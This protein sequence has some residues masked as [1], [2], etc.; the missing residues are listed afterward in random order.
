MENDTEIIPQEMDTEITENQEEVVIEEVPEVPEESIEDLKKKLA[1]AEAQKEHWRSKAK[2][3][4]VAPTA[5][6]SS[7]DLV[8]VTNAKIHEDDIERV[9]RFARSEGLSIKEAL[10]DPELN[11]MLDLRREQRN[12]ADATNIGNVRAGARSVPDEVLL[13]NA[14]KGKLPETDLEIE[15]LIMAKSRANQG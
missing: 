5:S 7:A 1:T 2:E 8:A 15:R 4:K 13:E 12:V 6:L 14:S 3:V 9:E 11:A 10:K